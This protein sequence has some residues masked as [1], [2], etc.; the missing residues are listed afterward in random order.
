MGIFSGVQR[1]D[2]TTPKIPTEVARSAFRMFDRDGDGVVDCREFCVGVTLFS[3]HVSA[4]EKIQ[5]VFDIFDVDSDGKLSKSEVRALLETAVSSTMTVSRPRTSSKDDQIVV[6][7]PKQSWIRT[8]ETRLLRQNE[9]AVTF[10]T[11]SAW[12]KDNLE[13]CAAPFA[14]VPTKE[15]ERKCARKLLREA[16][17]MKKGQTWYVVSFEWWNHWVYYVNFYDDDDEEENSKVVEEEEKNKH[18]TK[19]FGERPGPIDNNSIAGEISGSL[20]MGIAENHSFVL[21]PES[22]WH[23][24]WSWYGGGPIF[25]RNAVRS[26]TYK[27]VMNPKQHDLAGAVE[28]YPLSLTISEMNERTA[29]SKTST[30]KLVRRSCR[31]T[32]GEILL[33]EEEEEEEEAEE[34]TKEE[35]KRLWYRQDSR[36][37]WLHVPAEFIKRTLESGFDVD[38]ETHITIQD[39]GYFMIERQDKK[40]RWPSDLRAEREKTFRENLTYDV[41]LDARDRDGKWYCGTSSFS[42]HELTLFRNTSRTQVR[43]YVKKK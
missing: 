23:Q 10:E 42:Y 21:W 12:A 19:L 6:D 37:K 29:L 41:R 7:D 5:R 39:G 26:L 8:E 22:L 43:S 15:Y 36:Q 28:L 13:A 1:N 32:F 34:K 20:R 35:K 30:E 11:F 38:K 9:D 14:I 2:N 33:G 3:Q 24:M 17:N 25:P 18:V 27:G 40:D 4:K 31:T 16:Q